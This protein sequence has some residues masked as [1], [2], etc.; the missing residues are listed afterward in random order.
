MAAVDSKGR[1][2]VARLALLTEPS[3]QPNA[4]VLKQEVGLPLQ[5][6]PFVLSLSCWHKYCFCF[7]IA[8][9]GTRS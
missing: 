5:F 7:S 3:H 6:F 2:Q 8:T 4:S 9:V 1:T